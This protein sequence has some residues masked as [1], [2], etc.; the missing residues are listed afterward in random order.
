M[1]NILGLRKAE[2]QIIEE[3]QLIN[4]A[5]ATNRYAPDGTFV[6]AIG[7]VGMVFQPY[8]THQR[9]IIE[10]QPTVDARGN[11]LTFDGRLD[12]HAEIRNLLGLPQ[13]DFADS[14]IVLAAFE[15]WGDDCF[16][17][18]IGDWSL[19]LWSHSERSLYLARDHA[20]TRTLYYELTN[21]TLRWATHLDT[22]LANGDLPDLD[23]VYAACY[24]ACQPIRDLTPYKGIRAVSPA[25]YL[26]FQED[27][28]TKKPHWQ[29]IPKGTIYYQTD[30][31]YEEH[32]F[33][34]FRQSV[35]RRTGPGAPILAQLSGGM[36]ST[37]IVCMSDHIREDQGLSHDDL[38]DTVSYYDD[39]DPDW[40]EKPYFSCVEQAR[41]KKGIHIDASS[42]NS[43]MN[44]LYPFDDKLLV[45]GAN[46]P[47]LNYHYGS[48]S[49]VPSKEY[50]SI[51]SGIG[52]DELLGGVPT[53][54]PELADYLATGRP[55]RLVK[56]TVDWCL[57]TRRPLIHC[58]LETARYTYRQYCTEVLDTSLFPVWCTPHLRSLCRDQHARVTASSQKLLLLPSAIGKGMTWWSI[59]ETQPHLIPTPRVRYEYRYPYLD[60]SLVDF[61]HGIPRNQLVI[62]GRRRH[63][64][65]R[66]LAPI[67]PEAIRERRR[68]AFLVR[69]PLRGLQ[70][71]AEVIRST[72]ARLCAAEC[73]LV[74]LASAQK[75]AELITSGANV[76]HWPYL[77]RLIKFELWLRS[78]ASVRGHSPG[79][80]ALH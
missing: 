75:A 73:G 43:S 32:F 17:Q 23:K 74:D 67:V 8:H 42:T 27:E 22:F 63:L 46:N 5:H 35:E 24:L 66:S 56:R 16:S 2:G 69:S 9:S 60:K 45:P 4:L 34:L 55:C 37:S 49:S 53:G 57:A 14:S 1:S 80:P 12:N 13:T 33:A 28:V 40:N 59:L 72:V 30:M 39:S 41:Q 38:L 31:E 76:T 47:L 68:K 36:D 48:T 25:H 19:A 29:W 58:L 54:M 26:K 65:R 52:G 70:N 15:R 61:V 78:A 6:R 21:G 51:L 10:T 71:A 62:P 64:M 44:M 3:P 18:F 79:H 77:S 7:R 50:R 11:M 20:G